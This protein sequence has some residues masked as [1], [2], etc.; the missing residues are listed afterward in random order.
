[1]TATTTE[2]EMTA[3]LKKGREAA[4]TLL[5]LAGFLALVALFAQ[6]HAGD[7]IQAARASA[8]G[9]VAGLVIFGMIAG[10]VAS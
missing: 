7:V 6:Y 8:G 9:T 2:D 5:A 10:K 1:L 3:R 4:R